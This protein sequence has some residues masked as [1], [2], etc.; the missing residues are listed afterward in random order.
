MIRGLL[1]FLLIVVSTATFAQIP[2]L[3]SIINPAPGDKTPIYLTDTFDVGPSW[4]NIIWHFE[5]LQHF[6]T[7]TLITTA[8]SSTPHGSVFPGANIAIYYASD[9]AA[10][11]YYNA[12]ATSMEYVGGLFTLIPMLYDNYE[13]VI[14]YPFTYDSSYV[15]TLNSVYSAAGKTYHRWGT[16]TVTADAY[17]TLILPYGTF[18]NALLVTSIRIDDDTDITSP[19]FYHYI[20]TSYNW[21]VPGYHSALLSISKQYTNSALSKIITYYA[22]Q[23][24]PPTAI[25]E[26]TGWNAAV[27]LYPIPANGECTIHCDAGFEAGAYVEILGID[28]RPAARYSLQGINTIVPISH[29]APGLYT[30][31]IYNAGLQVKKLVVARQ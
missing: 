17:G 12:S 16:T 27:Q 8:C 13:D 26:P 18:H 30:C 3:T 5:N 22:I 7:D 25:Q 4:P 31:R 23:T 29:L 14:R 6:G 11:Y 20:D 15:D 19:T 24:P 1:A 2:T 28:G 21:Y 9:P 10:L